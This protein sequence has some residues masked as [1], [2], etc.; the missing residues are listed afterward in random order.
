M[1]GSQTCREGVKKVLTPDA[2]AESLVERDQALVEPAGE[3]P[4]R[5]VNVASVYA[6]GRRVQGRV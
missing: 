1:I 6:D 4:H 5:H 3:R 2:H